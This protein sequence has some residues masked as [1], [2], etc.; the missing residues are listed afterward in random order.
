MDNETLSDALSAAQKEFTPAFKDGSNPHFK[1]KFSSINE[2]TEATRPG[3]TNHGLAFTQYTD[4]RD[5][6]HVLVSELRFKHEK[7][8]SM[9]PI[10]LDKPSDS[11]QLGKAI[12]YISRYVMRSMLGIIA[13]DE[14]DDGNESAGIQEGVISNP[15]SEAMSVK[16]L[17]MI[18]GLLNSQPEREAGILKYYRIDNLS[19]LS[20]RYVNDVVSALKPKE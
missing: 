12:S 8:T 2:L 3:L 15:P 7:I 9:S 5:G 16:Q 17:A 13:T 14:D 6:V 10:I 18:K 11:Q 4:I 19:Q 1:S 20:W